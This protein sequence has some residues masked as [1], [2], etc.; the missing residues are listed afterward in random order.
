[1]KKLTSKTTEMQR[2]ELAYS[3]ILPSQVLAVEMGK[4]KHSLSLRALGTASFE[5]GAQGGTPSKLA[6]N[7]R[8]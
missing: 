8:G 4:G 2:C 6:T 1:M 7:A 3:L 5:E